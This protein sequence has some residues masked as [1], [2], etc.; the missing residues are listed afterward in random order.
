MFNRSRRK[1]VTGTIKTARRKYVNE[2]IEQI[3][4]VGRQVTPEEVLKFQE[5]AIK[6]VYGTQKELR[7]TY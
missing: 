7:Q 1:Y 4:K 2:Q 6:N 3:E 5:D